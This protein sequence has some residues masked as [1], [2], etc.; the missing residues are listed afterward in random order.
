VKSEDFIS[1]IIPNCEQHNHYLA[2][3]LRTFAAMSHTLQPTAPT[4]RNELQKRVDEVATYAT[5]YPY[6]TNTSKYGFP[7]NMRITLLYQI[8]PASINRKDTLITVI[9][10]RLNTSLERWNEATAFFSG[11]SKAVHVFVQ[12]LS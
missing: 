3:K 10:C 12:S 6:A 8:M 9:G 4:V 5:Q 11:K 2:L 7:D 1:T